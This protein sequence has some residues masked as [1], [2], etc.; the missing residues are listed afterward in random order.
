MSEKQDATSKKADT[1]NLSNDLAMIRT[2]LALDRTM[3]AWIRTSLALLGF[4]FT[5]AK[6]LHS[7]IQH[8]ALK[9]LHINSP[10][11][12]GI[13]LMI[14]G[15]VGIGGG[16]VQYF[17]ARL[18]LKNLAPES[19]QSFWSPTLLMA[20]VLFVASA[21]LTGSMLVKTRFW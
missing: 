17:Q 8:S 13:V 18:H 7:I 11:T 4:G 1:S 3:L 12:L 21:I 15:V 14:L 10:K 16:I 19:A 20:M 2:T 9:D 6:Y 5:F